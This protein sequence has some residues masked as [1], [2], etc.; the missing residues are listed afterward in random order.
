VDAR[1]T[2]V[3]YARR[4]RERLPSTIL[5]YWLRAS[6]DDTYGGF[7]L[8]DDV[9]R[10]PA[11]RVGRP[12]VRGR[13]SAPNEDKHLVTQA[14]LVWVFAHAHRHGL[15]V[16]TE[17]LDASRS[18]HAFL[19]EHFRDAAH[20]GYCWLT[21][22]AG[23]VR[24]D[25]KVLY[26]QAFVIYAFVELARASGDR[27][28]LDDALALFRAVDRELHDDEHG[29]WREHA[30]PDWSPLEEGDR[31]AELPFVGRKSQNA[32]V[33]WLEALTVLLD[34]SG[35]ASVRRALAEALDLCTG[36]LF[37]ADPTTTYDPFLV[38]WTRDPAGTPTASY[39]HNVEYAWLALEAQR[40]LGRPLDWD[41]FDA[42]LHHTLRCGFDHQ[43]GGAFAQGHAD[44][45]ASD[46]HKIWWVQCELM[47]ALTVA[48]THEWDDRAARAL[49]QTT[50]FV[51]RHLTDRRD[52]VLLE[53][54]HEDGRRLRPRKSGPWKAGYHDVRAA[55][56]IAETFGAEAPS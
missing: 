32:L 18:G 35:D 52:G 16:T 53:S 26:G 34:E 45:P 41:R 48:V 17:L 33:H 39:G 2:V 46:R 22:R 28:P 23:R 10:G 5:P 49:A 40:A 12:L 56:R 14:R 27:A 43:R 37:P 24:N 11:W 54:V 3:A 9:V 44:E 47:V 15:G 31:R 19:L 4:T 29:G 42:Y 55:V 25:V 13:R 50:T 1:A 36:H 20:D 38:D 6:R 51:E 30:E 8:P 21:D 7:R